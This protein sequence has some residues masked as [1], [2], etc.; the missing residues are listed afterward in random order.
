V[1]SADASA[2]ERGTPMPR[3][4]CGTPTRHRSAALRLGR[5]VPVV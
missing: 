2:Q 1:R 5:R 4:T 3:K